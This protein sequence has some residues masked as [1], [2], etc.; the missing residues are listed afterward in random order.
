MAVAMGQTGPWRKGPF[1]A[2]FLWAVGRF[3]AYL[4]GTLGERWQIFAERKS[5]DA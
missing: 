4:R 5:P 2:N 3:I 1:G